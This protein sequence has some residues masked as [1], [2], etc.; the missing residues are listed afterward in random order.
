MLCNGNG[1][2]PHLQM[3][4]VV[5]EF[6][7]KTSVTACIIHK[8]TLSALFGI[9]YVRMVI[10]KPPTGCSLFS[11]FH[12]LMGVTVM[13]FAEHFGPSEIL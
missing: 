8:H 7:F 11:N 12:F 13:E 1:V 5:M 9:F 2:L 10:Y 6:V 4:F 3:G